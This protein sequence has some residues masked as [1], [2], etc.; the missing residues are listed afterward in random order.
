MSLSARMFVALIAGLAVGA[1]A[2]AWPNPAFRG[3]IVAIEP[4]GTMWVNGIRMTVVPLVAS[5]LVV[6]VAS[7]MDVRTVGR[8]GGRALLFFAL[9]LSGAA[10][11]CG[12]IGPPLMA[13]VP[14]DPAAIAPLRSGAAGAAAATA[15]TV[16]AMPTFTQ[17][18]VDAVPTNPVRAAADGAMLPL[19]VFSLALG[20]AVTRI[21][22]ERR[23][24]VVDLLR[25]VSDAMLVLVRW[26]IILAP[27][28]VFALTATLAMRMGLGAAGAVAYYIGMMVLLCTVVGLGLYVV[29]TIG[30]RVSLARFARAVA[31]AQAVAVSSRSSLAAL[32]TLI[33]GARDR[34]GLPPAITGFALPLSVSLFRL[35]T[36][37]TWTVAIPFLA[38]LHGIELGFADVASLMATSVL[39]SFSVPGIPSA[40][41]FLIAPALVSYGIPVEGIGMLIAVDAIPDI[42]KTL[43]NVTGQMTA[44]VVLA[45]HAPPPEAT[46]EPV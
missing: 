11:I 3:A 22:P 7:G 43:L 26:L 14:V 29:A 40:G 17:W 28:G 32:P 42:F 15:E 36:P 24:A 16:R 23:N 35:N 34:L 25:G 45:R 18:L 12:A 1:A 5:L 33:D 27:A 13:G 10:L 37:V 31:P 46:P 4:V 8:L 20:A 6:G 44:A 39:V 38:R 21:A 2:Q 9:V 41:L 19:V 30:G